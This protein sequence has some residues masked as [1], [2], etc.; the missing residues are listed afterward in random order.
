[1][2]AEE[3]QDMAAFYEARLDSGNLDVLDQARFWLE[4]IED[5]L[6]RRDL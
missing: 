2:N 3:L 1:M 5:E 6:S 4:Q